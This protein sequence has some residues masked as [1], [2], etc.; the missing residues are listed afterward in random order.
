MS[1]DAPAATGAKGAVETIEPTRAQ[2]TTARRMAESKA[3]IPE[4]HATIEADATALGAAAATIAPYVAA[5]GRALREH[6]RLNGAYA[7]AKY[8]HYSRVNV[9]V[10]LDG[11][12]PVVVDADAKD[13][14]A[15]AQELGAF[16]AALRDG[17]LTGA[18][19]SGATFTLTSL[20]GH[21]VTAFTAIIQPGQS[22]ALAVGAPVS[23]DGRPVV[24]LTLSADSRIVS[25][26]DA[27]A[28]LARLG[29]LL[30]A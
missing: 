22:A 13:V 4:F 18:A 6:P 26:A 8:Q 24:T 29:E 7:D 14:A 25:P 3:T 23:R 1:A 17:T 9:G 28:F 21:G 5:A 15:I 16:D 20:A 2:R 19:Q 30:A 12:I 10:A 27:G 11:A